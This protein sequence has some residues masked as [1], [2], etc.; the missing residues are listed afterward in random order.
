M[1]TVE[2]DGKILAWKEVEE[3]VVGSDYTF[4]EGN[5]LNLVIIVDL[6][7]EKK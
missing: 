2:F 5:D 6:S 7:P 1:G 4:V 3:G